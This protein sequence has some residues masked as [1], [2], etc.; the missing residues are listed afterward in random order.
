MARNSRATQAR[1]R[2]RRKDERETPSLLSFS[3]GSLL[4]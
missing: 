2:R 4:S 1:R 3:L